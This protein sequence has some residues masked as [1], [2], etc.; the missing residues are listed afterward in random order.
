MVVRRRRRGGPAFQSLLRERQRV[1]ERRSSASAC[2]VGA[3]EE[4]AP[5][6]GQFPELAGSAVS[7]FIRVLVQALRSEFM[8]S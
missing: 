8:A 7:L 4:A 5:G 3:G 1:A 6:S 2:M